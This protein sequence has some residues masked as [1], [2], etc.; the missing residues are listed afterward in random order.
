MHGKLW[1]VNKPTHPPNKVR[2]VDVGKT[3]IDIYL[4]FLHFGFLY[5]VPLMGGNSRQWS[6]HWPWRSRSCRRC[7]WR[8]GGL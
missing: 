8:N 7:S 3:I 6:P 5:E 2:G 4:R 1:L